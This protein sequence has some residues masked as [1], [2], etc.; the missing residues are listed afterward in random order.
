MKIAII[1]LTKLGT[2]LDIHLVFP[3]CLF[4]ILG[5]NPGSYIA[6][7]YV[8]SVFLPSESVPQSFLAFMILALLLRVGKLFQGWYLN[9]AVNNIFQRLWWVYAF[10]I[11][12]PQRWDLNMPFSV[13]CIRV[14]LM[15]LFLIT[16][17]INLDYLVKWC[18]FSFLSVKLLLFTLWS[19]KI[20]GE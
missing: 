3:K 5:S 18:L 1:L 13:D 9:L 2:L 17:H 4:S 15:L 12:T 7:Y 6:Y 8:S 10:L 14:H 11:R 19:I 20:R 16:I